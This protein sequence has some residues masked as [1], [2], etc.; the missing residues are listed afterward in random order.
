MVL[1]RSSATK[2]SCDCSQESACGL[3]PCSPTLSSQQQLSHGEAAGRLPSRGWHKAV[4]VNL[5]LTLLP[6]IAEDELGEWVSHRVCKQSDLSI[7]EQTAWPTQLCCSLFQKPLEAKSWKRLL[8]VHF[9]VQLFLL[10][11]LSSTLCSLC[12]SFFGLGPPCSSWCK[13]K[14]EAVARK[15]ESQERQCALVCPYICAGE[16]KYTFCVQPWIQE[17]FHAVSHSLALLF[18]SF[19]Y[20][21]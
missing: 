16:M 10:S 4:L 8:L 3:Y 15:G 19:F 5:D 9:L 12:S 20:W 17:T 18:K 14:E 6:T 11:P 13:G 1:K 2:G 21:P 7:K